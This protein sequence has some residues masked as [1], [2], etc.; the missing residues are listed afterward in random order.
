MR[1]IRIYLGTD[2]EVGGQVEVAP[3]GTITI[4]ETYPRIPYRDREYVA[5]YAPVPDREVSLSLLHTL[6]PIEGR[7]N[8]QTRD[9]ASARGQKH[10]L[11][12]D[13]REAVLKWNNRAIANYTLAVG[14]KNCV[15]AERPG[16]LGGTEWVFIP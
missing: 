12:P 8:S 16:L 1:K 14:G 5:E 2:H 15:V 4:T 10:V 9:G 7:E 13:G 11:L 6:P 3:Y